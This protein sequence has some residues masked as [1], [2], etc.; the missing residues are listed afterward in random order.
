MIQVGF[1][2][3]PYVVA[4]P[5]GIAKDYSEHGDHAHNATI[6]SILFFHFAIDKIERIIE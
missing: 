3:N 5:R 2:I 4:L 1:S 6:I